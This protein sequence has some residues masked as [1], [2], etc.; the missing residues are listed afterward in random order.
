VAAIVGEGTLR[1]NVLRAM[2]G[3]VAADVVM[4][5]GMMSWANAD[6]EPRVYTRKEWGAA[7][8]RQAPHVLDH[9]PDHIIVHHTASPNATDLS[10]AHAFALSRRI[11]RDHMRNQGWDDIGEQLTISRG[12]HVMEGRAG[13][14]PAIRQGRLVVGAQSLHHNDHTIGIENEGTY[15]T[16][17]VPGRLWESLVD[18][19]AWLCAAYLLDPNEAIIGHRDYNSTDCPGD[20]LY[21]RLPRLRTEVARALDDAARRA[22]PPSD[23]RR[24]LVSH[25]HRRLRGHRE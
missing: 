25:R 7:P 4:V 3:A 10:R 18:V 16:D 24:R 13:S 15:L 19:C 14:L 5:G 8:P 20:V 21:R 1:R 6:A 11:Q 12:G 2:L 17:A 23:E 9:P 22:A